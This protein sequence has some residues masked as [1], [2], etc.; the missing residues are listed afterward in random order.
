MRWWGSRGL[1]SPGEG[2]EGAGSGKA[3]EG[4]GDGE[5]KVA[6]KVRQ[7]TTEEFLVAN[8][9]FKTR[10]EAGDAATKKLSDAERKKLEEDGD[11][12]KLLDAEREEKTK[13]ETKAK[14][15]EAENKVLKRTIEIRDFLDTAKDLKYP[16]PA[17]K[18]FAMTIDDGKKPVEE[19]VKAA[20][21]EMESL[22][23]VPGSGGKT[24]DLGGGGSGGAGGGSGEDEKIANL[25]KLGKKA[26]KSKS[27]Q[28][29]SA[30]D[31]ERSKLTGSGI[32]LP[33]DLRN[34]IQP[35]AV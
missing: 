21:A 4:S 16:I 28:D 24:D 20:V 34:R 25:I 22:G 35:D 9:E 27:P 8:P 32:K 6:E 2:G 33:A 18:K 29:I 23:L 31:T 7:M 3:K 26:M 19:L 1:R 5:G 11:T 14:T 10:L 12:K 13:H 30:Y 15:A 17:I